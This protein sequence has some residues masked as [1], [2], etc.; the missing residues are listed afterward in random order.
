MWNDVR[1]QYEIMQRLSNIFLII[2][3]LF[4]LIYTNISIIQLWSGIFTIYCNNT[5]EKKKR[6]TLMHNIKFNRLNSR[7]EMQ[8]SNRTYRDRKSKT[9]RNCCFRILSSKCILYTVSNKIL[10]M[11][12]FAVGFY[13]MW[14]NGL[15]IHKQPFIK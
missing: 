6:K 14:M 9:K 11:C 5:K 10:I 2:A 8:E 3:F 1:N 4:L 12:N 15:P 7:N 13:S